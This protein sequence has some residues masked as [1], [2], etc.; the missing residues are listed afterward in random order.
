[1][2]YYLGLATIIG[3]NLLSILE[4]FSTDSMRGFTK[5]LGQN[6]GQDQGQGLYEPIRRLQ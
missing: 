6:H 1:M 5:C 4:L 3:L 2:S